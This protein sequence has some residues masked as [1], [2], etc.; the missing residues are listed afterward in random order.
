[1]NWFNMKKKK[2]KKNKINNIYIYIKKNSDLSGKEIETI[3]EINLP[4]LTVL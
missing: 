1:M 3:P 2:K 4:G